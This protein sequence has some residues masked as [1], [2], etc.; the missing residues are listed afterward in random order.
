[1]C[2]GH[3]LAGHAHRDSAVRRL[4]GRSH[5]FATIPNYRRDKRWG[6]E[7]ISAI[8]EGSYVGKTLHVAWRDCFSAGRRECARPSP[9]LGSLG[10]IIGSEITTKDS[11]GVGGAAE[12]ARRSMITPASRLISRS[13]A[14]KTR[15]W[16][17]LT[18][19]QQWPARAAAGVQRG[20]Q[21]TSGMSR[22]VRRW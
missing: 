4:V 3:E 15:C 6:H 13:A 9:V 2:P 14:R 12:P 11:A 18:A 22:S 10:V 19:L 16:P 20:S 7:E 1:M 17:A 5:R 21:M 8:V